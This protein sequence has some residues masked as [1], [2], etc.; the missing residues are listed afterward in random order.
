MG[1]YR[2]MSGYWNEYGKWKLTG[3][4]FVMGVYCNQQIV[5]LWWLLAISFPLENRSTSIGIT[6]ITYLFL[7][8]TAVLV[9]HLQQS[10]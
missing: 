1:G 9:I 8:C 7:A 2:G 6:I 10:L 4:S 5:H 3:H